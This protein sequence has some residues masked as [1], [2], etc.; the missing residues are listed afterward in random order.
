MSGSLVTFLASAEC[1]EKR[2]KALA[3]LG[4]TLAEARSQ[5]DADGCCLINGNWDDLTDLEQVK[6]YDYLLGE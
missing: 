2:D 3:R 5:W 4:M 1:V 6:D